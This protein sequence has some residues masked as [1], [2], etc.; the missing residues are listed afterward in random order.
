[1][2]ANGGKSTAYNSKIRISSQDETRES[3]LIWEERGEGG[4]KKERKEQK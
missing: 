2:N 4:R 1:M 3:R